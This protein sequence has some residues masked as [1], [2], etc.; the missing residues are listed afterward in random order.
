ML[1]AGCCVNVCERVL[2]LMQRD[3]TEMY[4]R[5]SMCVCVRERERE[6]ECVGEREREREWEREETS[7]RASFRAVCLKA[8]AAHTMNRFGEIYLKA[9]MYVYKYTTSRHTHTTINT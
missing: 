2:L 1:K 8:R 5:E 6:R 4:E 3:S 9:V 7:G